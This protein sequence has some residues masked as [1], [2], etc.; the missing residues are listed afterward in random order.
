[1]E[2]LKFITQPYEANGAVLYGVGVQVSLAGTVAQISAYQ[3]QSASAVLTISGSVQQ[4]QANQA[5]YCKELTKI[6]KLTV[7]ISDPLAL[8]VSGS[9]PLKL[10]T[11]VSDPLL[12]K[13]TVA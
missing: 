8:K 9:D 10:T 12:L 5:Q 13:I 1:M 2:T 6:K 7:S 11:L 4:E 3:Q